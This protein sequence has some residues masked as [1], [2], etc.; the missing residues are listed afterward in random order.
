MAGSLI[1][2]QQ[3]E[4]IRILLIPQLSR[5][6]GVQM[7][8]QVQPQQ[9]V[10]LQGRVVEAE[11]TERQIQVPV[12]VVQGDIVEMEEQEAQPLEV[13]EQVVVAGAVVVVLFLLVV[14]AVV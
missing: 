11:E 1:Q 9:A 10:V 12:V 14:V 5:V 13:M 2:Q 4:V 6:L 8:L 3:P 7:L